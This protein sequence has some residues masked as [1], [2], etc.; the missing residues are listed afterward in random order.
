MGF[1]AGYITP[2]VE[3]LTSPGVDRREQRLVVSH[4]KD[5]LNVG[6]GKRTCPSFNAAL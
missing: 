2:C 1:M 3:Y 6:W 5:T 4:P